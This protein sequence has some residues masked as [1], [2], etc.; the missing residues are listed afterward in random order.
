MGVIT[1]IIID[2]RDWVEPIMIIVALSGFGVFIYRVLEYIGEI[3]QKPLLGDGIS[4]LIEHGWKETQRR[5]RH[6]EYY[7]KN[8]RWPPK[9]CRGCGTVTEKQG[10]TRCELCGN[11]LMNIDDDDL[12]YFIRKKLWMLDK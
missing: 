9:V 4:E 2:T 8:G 11:T 6:R 12:P 7:V 3:R 1:G 10:I 5:K